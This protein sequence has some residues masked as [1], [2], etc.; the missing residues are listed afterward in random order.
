MLTSFFA[1]LPAAAKPPPTSIRF[2]DLL[3]EYIPRWLQ[4]DRPDD[5]GQP[6]RYPLANRK[7]P[8]SN[9]GVDYAGCA[10]L[11]MALHHPKPAWPSETASKAFVECWNAKRIGEYKELG[12]AAS[13]EAMR[14]RLLDALRRKWRAEEEALLAHLPLVI[15]KAQAMLKSMEAGSEQH[16]DLAARLKLLTASQATLA[17]SPTQTLD[18]LYLIVEQARKWALAVTRGLV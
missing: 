1:K 4:L 17:Q 5:E 7:Y 14:V 3:A 6:L 15:V 13:K 11:Y 9:Y 8:I 16:K 2:L 10:A 18:K 12:I